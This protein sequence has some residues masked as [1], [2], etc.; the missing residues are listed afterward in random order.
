[1]H[2]HFYFFVNKII[3]YPLKKSTTKKITFFMKGLLAW[4]QNFNKKSLRET[5]L[6]SILK[7]N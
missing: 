1:M 3:I 7:F 4:I 6:H 5:M 2:I